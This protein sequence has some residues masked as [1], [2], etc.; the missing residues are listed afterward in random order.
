MI[1]KNRQQAYEVETPYRKWP[2][3]GDHLESM[4]GKMGLL[5]IELKPVTRALELYGVSYGCWPLEALSESVPYEGPWSSMVATSPRAQ[6]LEEL[7]TFFYG[8]GAL[9]DPGRASSI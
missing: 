3:D 8:D 5:R 1:L 7:S 6:I 4:S 9:Q 2:R